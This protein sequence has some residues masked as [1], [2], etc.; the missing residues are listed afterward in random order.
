MKIDYITIFTDK[1]EESISFYTNT[2]GFTI[3]DRVEHPEGVTLVFM[4]DDEG[5]A[6]ELVD[7]GE[8]VPTVK[9]SPVALTVT[10]PCIVQAEKMVDNLG[11]PK[12]FGPLTLPSG[13]S[14]MHISDPNG[15]VVNFV[16]MG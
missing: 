4:T 6:F 15:V 13:V 12:T 7:T 3:T 9:H 5:R 1:L 8:K 16:Q 10:V 2:L 14:L 11:H